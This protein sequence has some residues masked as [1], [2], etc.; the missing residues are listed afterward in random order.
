MD[1]LC[2]IRPEEEA[3]IDSGYMPAPQSSSRGRKIAAAAIEEEERYDCGVEGCCKSF[4]HEH[5]GIQTTEQSG[6]VVSEETILNT[7][8]ES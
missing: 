5:V 4:K 6:L 7:N 3:L 8:F 2:F 1:E